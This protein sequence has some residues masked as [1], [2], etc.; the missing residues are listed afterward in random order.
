MKTKYRLILCCFFAA[1]CFRVF[2]QTHVSVPLDN[3]IYYV[4]EQAELRGLCSPLS[5]IRPYTQHTIIFAIREIL[6]SEDAEKLTRVEREILEQYL[7]KNAKPKSGL[8]WSRGR[9]YAEAPFVGD[10]HIASMNMGASMEM[11]GSAGAYSFTESNE[12]YWGTEVWVQAYVNGD[13]GKYASYGVTAEGG[14]I[15]A[16]RELLGEYNTFYQQFPYHDENSN[17]EFV[18][19]IIEVHTW[20][21]THF[22]YTY[23]KRWDSSVYFID[24]L[25]S[26]ESWPNDIAGGYNLLSEISASL[27]DNKLILRAGRLTHEWGIAPLG[28]SLAFNQMARPFF[29]VE[30]EFNPVSWFGISSLTGSLE[31][32]NAEGIYISP[33]TD[34]NA[35]SITVLQFRYKNYLFFDVV[36]A[37]I[38]PKRFEMGYP[39]PITS[40]FFN[41]NNVGKFDNMA[42]T[43]TG[44][45]QYPGLGYFW[46]SL[47]VDEMNLTSDLFTLDRQMLA[48][49]AG[50][51]FFLPFLSFSSIKL[52]YTRI[53]PYNYTHHRNYLPWYGDHRMEKAYLNNGV[54]LGH[55]LPPNSDELLLR[56]ETMPA[57]GINTHFQFQMIRHGADYGSSAVDGSNLYSELDPD[58]RDEHPVLRRY[59]LQD[60]AY[61]WLYIFKLGAEWT[62]SKLPA[63]FYCEAGT[64]I[65]YFTNID[66]PANITGDPHP[67]RIIDTDEYPKSTGFIAKFGIKIYPK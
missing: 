62:L 26:Y 53:N 65:S 55:Y 14:L 25:A 33:W 32:F 31:Y 8:D 12:R 17:E 51:G 18:N 52:S 42:L 54:S 15:K 20:P 9:F 46:G 21:L 41:Q 2:A 5:G 3:Q 36:D 35:F 39:S 13:L 11:E 29:A 66:A 23:R 24:N 61:Q 63:A 28:S 27:L 50:M 44:K 1:I 47:F 67:Y 10:A 4:L 64:V 58:K 38:W 57:K 60:G 45:A 19:R 48:I 22:P 7:E 40:N 56:F 49:Q 34:Q 16:P 37:A 43:F 6:D 59:F 30:G